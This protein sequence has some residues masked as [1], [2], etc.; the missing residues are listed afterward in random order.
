ME[1]LLRGRFCS[2]FEP[3]PE[4]HV[5]DAAR[6]CPG[7]R[8]G[9]A[10]PRVYR[11]REASERHFTAAFLLQIDRRVA[12][13]VPVEFLVR[14]RDAERGAGDADGTFGRGY[15]AFVHSRST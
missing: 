2:R 13:H 9:S 14:P 10:L 8:L 7:H 11:L 6:L 4:G 5:A 3:R 15:S 12:R 1:M